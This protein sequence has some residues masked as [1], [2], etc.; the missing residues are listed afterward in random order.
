MYIDSNKTKKDIKHIYLNKAKEL[1][2]DL[3]K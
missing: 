3:A 2:K 1:R